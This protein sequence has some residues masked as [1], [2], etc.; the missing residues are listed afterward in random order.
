MELS[1][2]DLFVIG[3]FFIL[4]LLIGVWS[5]FR[6]DDAEDYFVAGG[7][8]PWWL[9]GISHHVSGYS[10]AVF[11]AYA[12]LAYT[13]GFSVYIWWALTIGLT[14][15]ISAKVFPVF[16]VR[17]RKRFKIQSPL[18]FL[19]T[20]Y[21]LATQQLMAWSG[22][23]LKLFD[24]GAKWAAIAILLNV[25]T[26]ISLTWGI[27]ISGGISLLYITFGGLWAVIITDFAQFIVQIIAGLVMFVVV[28]QKLGG[29]ES[30]FTVW[31]QLPEGNAQAFNDPY[32]VGFALAF[33]FINFLSYN[34]GQWN[35]AT[36]YI[37][38]PTE[39]Q[40]SKA[41]W[42]SGALYLVWPLILFFPMWAAP[43]LLPDMEDP[44]QSY[45]ILTMELL[46]VGLIG[47]VI[48]SL[49]ANTMSMTSSDINTI[50]AVISRDILPAVNKKFRKEATSLTTARITT[51]L[52]TLGTIVIALQFERFGGV[53]GL[54]ISWFG[55]L[56][57][58][59]AIPMLF[60]LIPWF[61]SCGPK[62]AIGSILVG[63]LAFVITKNVELNS[64]ALE[65]SLPV[66]SSAI[67]Y[68]LVGFLERDTVPD[69]VK[70]M[71]S[72]IA[73]E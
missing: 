14:V 11:V 60:G 44:T 65:V 62:A 42:L 47:L 6:N 19:E 37:S 17:L 25:F 57:G 59:I 71:L 49:F 52:F 30:V 3:L 64:L 55:A 72:D 12:G 58:P 41:A 16:W 9:S 35:L 27:L 54:I 69:K 70:Q 39:Q 53:L 13:H 38:S 24:I 34:G 73:Q 67:T 21:N 4:M 18:E 28:V 61:K 66:L 23:I 10:G 33:L 8:L 29:L 46:P 32:T 40:A 15:I 31:D 50:S 48:A 26:G 7:K 63:L 22:V 20:R 51:F 36:R 45:G 43:V 5:Y 1:T 2:T 68:I 56:V